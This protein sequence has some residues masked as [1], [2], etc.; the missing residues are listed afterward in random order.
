LRQIRPRLKI[1]VTGATGHVGKHFLKQLDGHEV[2]CLS[3][4]PAPSLQTAN[5]RW[6]KGALQDC[7]LLTSAL[8]EFEPDVAVHLAW[9]GLPNYS[10]DVCDENVQI[11]LDLLSELLKTSV[12]RIV[13]AGS[14]FEYGSEHGELFE[15]SK[16]NPN[17]DYAK[18]KLNL[19][20]EFNRSCSG[21][22]VELVWSRIFCSFG[23][24]K[25]DSSLLPIVYRAMVNKEVPL[26]KTP[27]GTQ[28]FVF[29][30]DVASAIFKL[31]T[32]KSVSGLFNI[33]SGCLTSVAQIVNLVSEFCDS[34][35]RI[36]NIEYLHGPWASIEKIKKV[37]GW[38]PRYTLE[39]GVTESLI[40]LKRR[41]LV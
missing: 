37:T 1:F 6:V 40:E 15:S 10:K 26:V 29:V 41:R 35:F 18:A 14:G 36:E 22:N 5:L 33:G 30:E 31:A 8:K 32:T 9:Q 25:P 24:G 7:A 4:S 21:A 20:S 17:S 39:Q 28:D 38:E 11:S 2:L 19:F 3:R 16:T 27:G 12:K 13:V 23:P 34:D